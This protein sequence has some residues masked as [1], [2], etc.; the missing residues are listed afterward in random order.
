M[1]TTP[2]HIGII[3]DGNG[4]WAQ[5]RGLPRTAGHVEGMKNVRPI[6]EA[7]MELNVS[8]LTVYAFSTENW[9]RPDHEVQFLMGLGEQFLR[10]EASTLREND[11]RVQLLGRRQRLPASLL[12]G[13]DECVELTR[14]NN[15]LILNVALNYGGRMEILDACRE[16]I[17]ARHAGRLS[18]QDLD[19]RVF[20]EHL[21]TAG[22]RDPD[23][24]IRTGGEHRISNF[25]IWQAAEALL[26][27][28]PIFWPDFRE[29]HLLQ[30]VSAYQQSIQE[31]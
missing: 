22:L 30:A 12:A 18:S 29:E 10:R 21:Y 15:G 14:H 20:A 11:V 19:E 4:R 1:S 3:M 31:R 28:T 16:L 7:C 6:T 25:L 24:I 13:I 2:R 5:S 9:Q 27:V 8:I 26:W 17:A 23:L